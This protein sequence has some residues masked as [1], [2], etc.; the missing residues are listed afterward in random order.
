[1]IEHV[2]QILITDK[3][4]PAQRFSNDLVR[5]IASLKSVYP[6]ATYKRY[7]NDEIVAFLEQYFPKDVSDAYHA[8]TP[9]AF[10][11]DLARYCLLHEY[12]GLYS[13][14]S[15]LHMHP[16]VPEADTTL[17]AFRDI[18]EQ[19]PWATSN[20]IIYAKP[21]VAALG[22]AIDR[23]V[24][25]H[26][27]QYYGLSPLDPTGPNMFGR[28]LSDGD[29][30]NTTVLGESRLISRE[31]NGRVNILKILPD[32]K[33]IALRNKI[34]SCSIDEMVEGHANNY[35]DLWKAKRI[36]GEVGLLGRLQAKIGSPL[37]QN[38]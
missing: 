3:S 22:R 10:K 16:L 18:P 30:W 12:G 20:A 23:I 25:N 15:Y 4:V 5:N 2:F 19:P 38:K 21:K 9:Y 36:W 14:L 8:M 34:F 32:G 11:A 17:V 27:A 35:L 28:A 37:T 7:E 1:M 31:K 33:V 24:S 13:D 6:G 26:K 29:D